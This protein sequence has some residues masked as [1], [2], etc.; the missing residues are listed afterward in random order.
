MKYFPNLIIIGAM[1]SGSTS[2]H[3]L[4][5]NHPDIFMSE[6]KEINFFID[7]LNY[8]KG[9]DW[10][11]S[12]F[13]ENKKYR[14][15][16]SIGYTKKDSF[17]GVPERIYQYV[18]DA[19]LIYL[20][21]DPI[22]RAQSHFID[23]LLYKQLENKAYPE[24]NKIFQQTENNPFLQASMYYSQI[25]EYLPFFKKEQILIVE[26]EQL[27]INL[28]NTL[29]TI[30]NF[31]Q[32]H[33]FENDVLKINSKNTSENKRI[34]SNLMKTIT[35]FPLLKQIRK[36]IPKTIRNSIA[37]SRLYK[38]VTQEEV[39]KQS[40]ELNAKTISILKKYFTDEMNLFREF[41][42]KK[43]TDWQV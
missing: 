12:H 37:K 26:S 3:L 20:V 14:G 10:Y 22:A 42:G 29:N 16:S 18:P 40:F 6:E 27:R 7:E 25:K 39:K 19:K 43:F 36:N 28:T 8:K 4:L 34:K 24:I 1:K 35:G 30:C 38:K 33:S 17:K 41:S 15:E 5:N 9:I 2:L 13:T 11:K 31:L 32:I 23:H 21:R